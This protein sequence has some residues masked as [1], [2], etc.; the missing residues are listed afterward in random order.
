MGMCA[1]VPHVEL[2]NFWFIGWAHADYHSYITIFKQIKTTDGLLN[3]ENVPFIGG[4]ILQQP[5]SPNGRVG[6]HCCEKR[7]GMTHGK[8]YIINPHFRLKGKVFTFVMFTGESRESDDVFVIP[9]S[10]RVD[11]IIAVD[12]HIMK[13]GRITEQSTRGSYGIS[14]DLHRVNGGEGVCA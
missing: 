12:T 10:E 9:P 11:C 7:W 2:I 1:S 6:N 5:L 3:A 14:P 13:A 4:A 8:C